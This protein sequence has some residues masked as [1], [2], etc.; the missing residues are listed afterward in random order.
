MGPKPQPLVSDRLVASTTAIAPAAISAASSVSTG[1]ATLVATTTTWFIF[2]LGQLSCKCL[3]IH[4]LSPFDKLPARDVGLSLLVGQESNVQ[5]FQVLGWREILLSQGSAG[6]VLQGCEEDAQTVDLY[7][8][9]VQ[10]H[11]QQTASEFLQHS[12]Y[13]VWGVDASVFRDVVGHLSGVQCFDGFSVGKPLTVNLR[14]LDVVLLQQIK[15]LC[16]N[17][18]CFNFKMVNN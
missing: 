12:E 18:V 1:I 8:F 9:R 11:L 14:V 13:H 4:K 6:L 15:N 17:V 5:G 10:Q 2:L 3:G 16:H 7:S